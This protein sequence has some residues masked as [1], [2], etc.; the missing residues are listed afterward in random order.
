MRLHCDQH[1]GHDGHHELLLTRPIAPPRREILNVEIHEI[2]SLR[3]EG[4]N[5][6]YLRVHSSRILLSPVNSLGYVYTALN[7]AVTGTAVL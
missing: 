6:R 5:S 2:V 1:G 4:L 7:F 3:S